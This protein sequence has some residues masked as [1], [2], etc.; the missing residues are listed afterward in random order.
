MSHARGLL[1]VAAAGLLFL[2]GSPERPRF[3]VPDSIV[4]SGGTLQRR[5]ALTDRKEIHRFSSALVHR[6]V[7]R[8]TAGRAHMDVAVFFVRSRRWSSMPLDSVPFALADARSRY[9]PAVGRRP[10]IWVPV[11][12]LSG[13]GFP[14]A[15][16][17][18]SALRVLSRHGIPTR[19]R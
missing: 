4:F 13:N 10:A 1:T 7:W 3:A 17:G 11:F 12:S 15:I 2:G 8:D 5:I 6:D 16:I 9:Y 18:D 14:P 19:V